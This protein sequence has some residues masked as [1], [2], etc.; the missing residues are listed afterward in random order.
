MEPVL[1]A[2]EPL[3]TKLE[4]EKEKDEKTAKEAVD[5]CPKESNSL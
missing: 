4:D 5:S 3:L 2:E 1:T